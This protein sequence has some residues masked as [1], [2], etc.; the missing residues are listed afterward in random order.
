[1]NRTVRISKTL[2]YWLR[3]DPAAGGLELDDGG[4][5]DVGRVLEALGRAFDPPVS[6]EELERVV[7]TNDKKRFAL[8]GGRIRASQG[9]S[10]DVDLAPRRVEP[11]PVLY[12]GTTRERWAKIRESGGLS[13]MRPHHVHLSGDRETARRVGGRHRR[14]EVLVLRVDAAAMRRAGHAFFVSENGVYLTDAVSL[15]FLIP[16]GE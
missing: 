16:E 7:A 5:A 3:H 8:E 12:H 11:P 15:E 6:R 13:K 10:V 14:E 4:W 1:M 2:S 9:H